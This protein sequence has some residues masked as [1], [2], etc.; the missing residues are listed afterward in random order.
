MFLFSGESNKS[1]RSG[2]KQGFLANLKAKVIGKKEDVE[3]K[4]DGHYYYIEPSLVS[5]SLIF[6]K[7]KLTK[8]IH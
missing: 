4:D 5:Y 2:K 8:F 7:L 3:V 6:S 1:P